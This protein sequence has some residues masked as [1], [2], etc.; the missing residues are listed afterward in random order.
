MAKL[1]KRRIHVDDRV[2]EVSALVLRPTNARA[3]L[4]LAHGAGVGMQHTSMEGIAATLAAEGIA[5]LRYQF[6]YME[7][8]SRA[9]SPRSQLL[10]TIRAG[11][12]AARDE[13]GT[14]PLFA[15]GKS[16]G[17]RMTS[18]AA[19][20]SPLEGV[21]GLVFFG[22]PLH[23]ANKPSSERADHLASVPLPMLFLQG[24]R[25][26]LADLDL[27]EP[28]CK[29]LG[30]R[31]RLVRLEGA[32]HSFQVLKRSDRTDAEVLEEMGAATA[33]FVDEFS[34]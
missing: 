29:K 14:L 32:D 2:G 20:G 28:I 5:S 27:L 4:A 1:E 7:K 8:G 16:M 3:L 23:P 26:P 33:K 15:G 24:T 25:D 6:P 9:I 11:I 31:A 13:A 10:A 30:D 22:F 12:D 19:V 17:G 18:L 21:R 34:A